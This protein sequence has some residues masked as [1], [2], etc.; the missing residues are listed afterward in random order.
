MAALLPLRAGPLAAC[1]D[2]ADLRDLTVAG[3]L[4]VRRVYVAVRGPDWSTVPSVITELDL[5]ARPD[6]FTVAFLAQHTS[7]EVDFACR[8]TIEG[9]P[10]GRIVYAISGSARSTFP[11]CRI[12]ICVEH[13]DALAGA[14]FTALTEAGTVSGALPE[15]IAPQWLVEGSVVPPIP[16]FEALTVEARGGARIRVATQG[17]ILEMEDHRNWTDASFKSYIPPLEPGYPFLAARGATV[18]QR[19]ELSGDA[20]TGPIRSLPREPSSE[21]LWFEP[22]SAAR[23]PRLG[24]CVDPGGERMPEDQAEL[25]ALLRPDHLRVDVG[26]ADVHWRARLDAAV[27]DASLV[28]CA[29]EVAVHVSPHDASER[30]VE[31]VSSLRGTPIARWLVLDA[32]P[33]HKGSTTPTAIRL[34]RD[35][36]RD[37]GTPGRIAAGSSTDFARLNR[38]RL[39]GEPIDALVYGV[40]P[41]VHADDD[42]S[43]M[44]NARSQAI[45]VATAR[46]FAE[47]RDVIISPIVLARR[48]DPRQASL[49][50][51]AWTVASLAELEPSG[52]SSLTYYET[53][54]PRGLVGRG[55]AL[56][57]VYHVFAQLQRLRKVRASASTVAFAPSLAGLGA[58]VEGGLVA[59]VANLTDEAKVARVGPFAMP[60]QV[61]ILDEMSLEDARTDPW[62]VERGSPVETRDGSVVLH[63]AP[64]A[65]AFLVAP[66]SPPG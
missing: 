62:F 4:L 64:Y 44:Q 6:N 13:A 16:A 31:I 37:G 50:G 65:S 30:V 57:P 61:R 51:T 63:L 54:G 40:S 32:R 36:L 25:V 12:G 2:G 26:L 47:G 7:G 29:L 42:R 17:A 35:A 3:S 59:V 48:D 39:S 19:I 27:A 34:L 49:L 53:V 52:A 28:G 60:P 24:F 66:A 9:W 55:P 46:S 20:P 33:D 10:D 5:E 56:H 43:V 8:G 22:T 45:T 15:L 21:D 11:Y 38:D 1:L 58:L 23:L 41:S 14:P 18:A